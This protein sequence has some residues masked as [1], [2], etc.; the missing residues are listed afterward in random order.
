[1]MFARFCVLATMIAGGLLAAVSVGAQ[2]SARGSETL[3]E[4]VVTGRVQKLYRALQTT[5]GKMPGAPL[6]IPQAVQVITTQLFEDQGA[7]DV[8]DLIETSPASV[9]FHTQVSLSVAS[10]RK[11]SITMACAAI[12]SSASR[13]RRRAVEHGHDS[14]LAGPVAAP[15]IYIRVQLTVSAR[16]GECTVVMQSSVALAA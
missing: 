13:R 1:M 2:E 7:R 16:S 12:R 9:S 4:V 8:T 11:A 10:G 14:G 3:E 15:H 5:V 6:D